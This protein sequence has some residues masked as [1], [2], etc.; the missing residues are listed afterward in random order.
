MKRVPNQ[1]ASKQLPN[2]YQTLPSYLY[3]YIKQEMRRQLICI[4]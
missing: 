2:S 1:I 4:T 3:Y